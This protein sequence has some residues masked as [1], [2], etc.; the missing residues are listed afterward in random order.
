MGSFLAAYGSKVEMCEKSLPLQ[1]YLVFRENCKGLDL[2]AELKDT[3]IV[4]HGIFTDSLRLNTL[5]LSST[6]H[7][8]WQS[9]TSW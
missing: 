7:G 4:V 1:R 9:Q 8:R 2:V 5:E 6:S 3:A